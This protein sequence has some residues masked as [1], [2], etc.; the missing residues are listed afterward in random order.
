MQFSKSIFLAI[1]SISLMTGAAASAQTISVLSGDGQVLAQ[2]SFPSTPM[3][4]LVRNAQGQPAPGV[5]VTWT[6]AS[7]QG[8]LVSLPNSF[9][10]D[11]MGQASMNFVGSSL[12]GVDFAQTV[13]TAA[14]SGSSVNFT[15]TTSGVDPVTNAPFVQA[16]VDFPA[17]SDVLTGAAGSTGTS[18]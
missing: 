11:S 17:L 10:T 1:L 15:M 7:G 12:S 18:P 5:Q 16:L 4:V 14:S 9:L 3:T 2:N 6:V 13:V 8:A